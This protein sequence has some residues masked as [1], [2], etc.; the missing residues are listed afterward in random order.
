MAWT[1]QGTRLAVLGYL[2]VVVV[3]LGGLA[4]ATILGL[5]LERADRAAKLEQDRNRD[6]RLAL[7]RLDARLQDVIIRE[8]GRPP[9][10][11]KAAL[12]PGPA[13]PGSACSA[14]RDGHAALAGGGYDLRAVA[15]RALP[16]LCCLGLDLA[17]G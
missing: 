17:A 6:L 7:R 9:D 3:V 15:P 8:T 5:R 11:Y 13:V 12:Q 1:K 16:G 2:L 4:W 14:H 10:Q